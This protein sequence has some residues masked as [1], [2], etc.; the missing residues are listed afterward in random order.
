G[1]G[2]K[3]EYKRDYHQN[4]QHANKITEKYFVFVTHLKSP[5]FNWLICGGSASARET[6]AKL[7]RQYSRKRLFT[8]GKPFALL[9]YSR[10]R[11]MIPH[12]GR[13]IG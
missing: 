5:K 10:A 7:A 3:K 11:P 6:W 13:M 8:K 12:E 9:K 1:V 4:G 2:E